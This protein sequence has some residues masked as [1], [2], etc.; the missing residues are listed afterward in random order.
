MSN[1]ETRCCFQV[2]KQ[3]MCA[4]TH[5]KSRLIWVKLSQFKTLQHDFSEILKNNNGHQCDLN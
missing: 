2:Q 3:E 1:D 5:Q 4:Q